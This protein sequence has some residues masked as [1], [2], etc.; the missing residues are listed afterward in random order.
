MNGIEQKDVLFIQGLVNLCYVSPYGLI[1][2]LDRFINH[3]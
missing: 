3:M 2:I 1:S